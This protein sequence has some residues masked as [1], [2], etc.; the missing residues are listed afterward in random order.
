MDFCL[1]EPILAG[2]MGTDSGK[3]I[4]MSIFL[5]FLDTGTKDSEHQKK[6]RRKFL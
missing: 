3:V 2:N 4:E 5:R 6:M 1:R